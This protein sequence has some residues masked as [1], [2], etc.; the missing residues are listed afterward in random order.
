MTNSNE[1]LA[2][3]WK[4]RR[5]FT[6]V[7]VLVFAVAA[8][9]TFALPKVY[10]S[11]AFLIVSTPSNAP[12]DF[13]ATQSTALRAKTYADLVQTNAFADTVD[14]QLP[15]KSDGSVTVDD[16]PDSQLIEIKASDDTPE[17]ARARAN[18]YALAVVKR[19]QSLQGSP[20]AARQSL[21]LAQAAPLSTDPA[22]PRPKL[23]LLLGAVLAFFVAAAMALLRNR[24]DQRLDLDPSATEVLGLPILARV[25]QS[26]SAMP[27]RGHQAD[28]A[29]LPMPILEAFRLLLA[30]LAFANLGKRPRT[31]AVVSASEGEGKSTACL[32]LGR[33][34]AGLGLETAIVDADLRRPSLG[35]M[36]RTDNGAPDRGLSNLL[37][38][39]SQRTVKDVAVPLDVS[40]LGL[41]AAGPLPPNPSALL[42]SESMA[43]VAEQAKEAFQLT[44]FDT[45]PLSV[46]ADASLIA[47]EVEGVIFVL[48]VTKARRAGAVQAVDQLRRAQG[49]VLGVVLNRVPGGGA[50]SYYL[51]PGGRS[52]L[53]RRRPARRNGAPSREEKPSRTK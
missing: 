45:P 23:Y 24:L 49:N 14:R 18:A 22:R 37:V 11:S 39:S 53:G 26:A 38:A 34:A 16:I 41:I 52:R 50:S 13:E 46:G 19:V 17:H 35:S 1:I 12:S 3:L 4:R 47:S 33:A 31:I 10:D 20:A 48:D 9:V 6:L 43:T 27:S 15:F 28:D 25:P 51:D 42:A 29:E 2:V 40:S 32:S 36:V 5:T 44:I 8:V 21:R 7:F 30:N